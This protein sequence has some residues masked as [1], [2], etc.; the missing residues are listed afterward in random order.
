MNA[1][2][3]IRVE[4]ATAEIQALARLARGRDGGPMLLGHALCWIGRGVIGAAV[5]EAVRGR[6]TMLEEC[7]RIERSGP[8]VLAGREWDVEAAIAEL[9]PGRI[10]VRTQ[11]ASAMGEALLAEVHLLAIGQA[12]V[13]PRRPQ[14]RTPGTVLREIVFTDADLEVYVALSGDD[15]ALHVDPDAAAR[16]GLP[17]RAVHGALIAAALEDAVRDWA[18]P[19]TPG[20]LSA[21][22]LGVLLAGGR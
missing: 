18:G 21:R 14:A 5:R 22:F 15:N 13:P 16:A 17:R 20:A 19:G 10:V 1:A 2:A 12:K 9:E 6:G 11:A 7:H 3:A 4:S 8:P